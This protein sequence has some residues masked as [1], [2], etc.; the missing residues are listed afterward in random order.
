MSQSTSPKF[1]MKYAPHFGMF[2][3]SAGD[4]PVDQLKFAADQGFTAWEE[5]GM[6][7]YSV[8]DQERIAKAM[9]SLGI[10]MGIFVINQNDSA[11][12]ATLATGKPEFTEALV[13]ECKAAVEVAK[14]MNAKCM[15][16]VPGRFDEK[17]EMNYQTA[18]VI[19]ALKHGAAVLEPHG[20]SMVIEAL[21]PYRDHP[22][23]YLS[24]IPQSY[25][26]CRSVGSP[27]CKILFD[28]YH[29]SIT[30][31]NIIPNIDLAWS[32]IAYFQIGDNPGRNEPTTGEVNYRRIFEHLNQKGYTG[33]LGTEHGNSKPGKEGEAAVIE[34]Y[35]WCDGF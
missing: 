8:P 24:K 27:G 31:G 14:R 6:S 34:A 35:R 23:M 29:Q 2:R 3:N 12:K 21:N 15:T 4:D 17:L 16:Y 26:I 11:W 19:E 30:E 32:E 9:Q 18:N 20:L 22:G 7:G 10:Q 33:I 1:R 13:A 25:M 28:M 5:N